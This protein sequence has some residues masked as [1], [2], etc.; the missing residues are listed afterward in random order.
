MNCNKCGSERTYKSGFVTG[1]QRYRCKDCGRQFVPTRRH[2]RSET[3]KLTA[4][5]LYINGLSLRTIGR[6]LKVS[7]AA[8]LKWVRQY[9]IENYE[10]PMPQENAVIVELDE[11]WHYLHVKK[12]N[13]GYGR[14]IVALPISSSTGNAGVVIAEPSEECLNGL[15][16][17][18]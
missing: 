6:L 3:E 16:S 1:E 8:V 5:L 15:N 17:G 2:G 14:L 13:S 4:V 12:T 9:A 10:K 11:M 7:A 18:M